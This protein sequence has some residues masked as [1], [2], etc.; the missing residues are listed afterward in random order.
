M[1]ILIKDM[2]MPKNCWECPMLYDGDACYLSG[3]WSDMRFMLLCSNCKTDEYRLGQFPYKEK[4]VD[5]CPLE[6]QKTGR[7]DYCEEAVFGNPY[8]SYKCSVCGNIEPHKTN[9]CPNCG[10][11]MKSEENE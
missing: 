5:W 3:M 1:S 10:A 2:K 8:G 9:Y 6:E 7:W 11:R 4:R